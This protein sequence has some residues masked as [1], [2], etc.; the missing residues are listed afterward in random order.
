[1]D[2]NKRYVHLAEKLAEKSTSKFRLG[3]VIVK[4]GRVVSVGYNSM[5]KTHP[6]SPT[7]GNHL[8]SEIRALIST[9]KED[10]YNSTVYVVR[11]KRDGSLGSSRPCPVCYEAL[12]LANI[13]RIYYFGSQSTFV[14]EKL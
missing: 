14:E 13:K 3:C 8:H 6:K 5:E 1:M 9:S 12:K 10:L 7:Y 2:K 4:K 11:I